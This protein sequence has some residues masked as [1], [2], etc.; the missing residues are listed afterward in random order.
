MDDDAQA[1]P[2]WLPLL[3]CRCGDPRVLGASGTA[4]P[5]WLAS[6]PRWFPEEFYWVVGCSYRGLPETT[7]E[8]RNLFGGCS[9]IKREVF[10]RVGGFRTGIG[11][12]GTHP[13]G[14]E[15]T[16]LCIRARQHWPNS[17]F[18]FE[19]S[20]RI[21]HQVPPSRVQWK[22]YSSRCF[23]EGFSKAVIAA[24]VGV[25]DGLASERAYT[26]R[27]LPG[28]VARGLADTIRR[29]DLTGIVRAGAIVA[30]LAITA[31]GYAA[32]S[33]AQRLPGRSNPNQAYVE[34][35]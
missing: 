35:P 3:V 26:L 13:L 20:A 31:S 8:V 16:E 7:A 11:R 14:G 5:M 33:I 6:R 34:L 30:G 9:C 10:E 24:Y 17:T 2:D 28:G 22:Y 15:E 32:G 19:P 12:I 23:W 21:H 29:G 27:T 18:L 1:E 4:E 25:H